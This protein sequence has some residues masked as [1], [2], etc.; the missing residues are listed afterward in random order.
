MKFIFALFAGLSDTDDCENVTCE[1]G[2]SCNDGTNNYM[3]SCVTGYT[4][5][6]CETGTL[7]S[8]LCDTSTPLVQHDAQFTSNL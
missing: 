1:H 5:Q 4:G 8:F 7:S 3:C 6:H 2:G